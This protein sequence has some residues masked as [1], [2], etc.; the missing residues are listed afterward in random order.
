MTPSSHRPSLAWHAWRMSLKKP[1]HW[2]RWSTCARR[3][4]WEG[5]ETAAEATAVTI[6]THVHA[7]SRLHL[8]RQVITQH[9]LR[10]F[11]RM[12]LPSTSSASM[13]PCRDRQQSKGACARLHQDVAEPAE[14]AVVRA[15]GGLVRAGLEKLVQRVL[16]GGLPL[17]L[18]ERGPAVGEGVVQDLHAAHVGAQ[19]DTQG[20]GADGNIVVCMHVARSSGVQKDGRPAAVP[21][22]TDE[23]LRTKSETKPVC[24]LRSSGVQAT[25]AQPPGCSCTWPRLFPT[26]SHWCTTGTQKSS[27]HASF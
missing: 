17:L 18:I 8:L 2:P 7:L 15:D 23:S 22:S 10:S 21:C 26:A 6:Q 14:E 16:A 24:W 11:G 13:G 19:Q 1:A 25:G 3:T 20:A 4:C 5:V 12:L 9:A 27:T